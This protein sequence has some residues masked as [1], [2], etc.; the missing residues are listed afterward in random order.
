MSK[1]VLIVEDDPVFRNYL[2]MVL[3]SEYDVAIA[4]NPIQAL[5][6]LSH[7]IF[8]LIITDLRMPEMDGREFVEKVHSEI[9]P[10]L[11]VIVVTAFEDDWP[12][13]EGILS[14]T[15]TF[16]RKGGFLPSELKSL[17]EKAIGRPLATET[18]PAGLNEIH[19]R[20]ILDNLPDAVIVTDRNLK[21]LYANRRFGTLTGL[22]M[23]DMSGSLLNILSKE[24][25][26]KLSEAAERVENNWQ[27]GLDL[28]MKSIDGRMMSFDFTLRYMKT[29]DTD[30]LV[31]SGNPV[32]KAPDTGIG[33]T[34]ERLQGIADELDEARSECKS[35]RADFDRIAVD[36]RGI[37]MWF[38]GLFSCI[39]INPDIERILG[40]K[41]AVLLSDGIPWDRILHPDDIHIL[42][43]ILMAAERGIEK[44]SG[45]VRAYS[46]TGL[47]V[48]LS[49]NAVFSYMPDGKLAG[50]DIVGEDITQRIIAK[51]ELI[52]AGKRIEEVR[53][54]MQS[55]PD[56]RCRAIVE[57]SNNVILTLDEDSRILYVNRKG[58]AELALS[59]DDIILRPFQEFISDLT[60]S[61]RFEA[62]ILKLREGSDPGLLNISVDTVHGRSVWG[63][64]MWAIGSSQSKIEYAGIIRDMTLEISNIKKL[65]LFANIEQ[66]SADAIIGYDLERRIISW[67]RGASMMFGWSEEEILGNYS[68]TTIVPEERKRE[69]D[70]VLNEVIEKGYIRDL[71]T[72]RKTKTGELLNVILTMTALMDDEGKPFGFSII[73]KDITRQKK[74]EAALLQSERLAAMGKLSASIAHEINNPLYGIKSCLKHILNTEETKQIDSQFVRLAI[75]ETDRIAELI[76]NM[77]TFYQPSE[78]EVFTTDLNQIIMETLTFNRKYLEEN[79]VKLELNLAECPYILAVPEQIKQVFLNLM[80]NAAEAMPGGGTLTVAT[81]PGSD[82]KSVSIT[83]E[84]TGVGIVKEDIPRLFD[85]FYS[86]KPNVKGVGLGLSVSYG[87]IKRHGG[88]IEVESIPSEGT[89]FKI[90]L[91]VTP[92]W[93]RQLKL[94]LK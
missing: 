69:S 64:N 81:M 65:R 83:F 39:Y 47:L 87:I 19:F 82:G 72:V 34:N 18:A 85:M 80:T 3:K 66:Y 68:F 70:E 42:N 78:G 12:E 33:D 10:G 55:A 60:S 90:I 51:N 76:R 15:F 6:L 73:I 56:E 23:K 9:F 67:N 44:L 21:P 91:P 86:K 77:K 54:S 30:L 5:A 22:G 14:H 58:L 75:K 27:A 29:Q 94:E 48:Y 2:F 74:M 79:K 35:V 24:T 17:V 16:L 40:Y 4:A 1:K 41:A 45:D 7:E 11:P 46:R 93:E 8:D 43:D 61:A 13:E 31:F 92:G 62:A 88:T 36:A 63:M 71:E 59:E 25:K 50:V 38:D 26:G 28:E 37:I 53:E 52:K 32:E 84:D 57:G 20:D 89:C 49:L